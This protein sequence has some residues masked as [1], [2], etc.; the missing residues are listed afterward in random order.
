MKIKKEYFV[1]DEW[2]FIGMFDESSSYY[3]HFLSDND[4]YSTEIGINMIDDM[5][6]DDEDNEIDDNAILKLRTC[7]EFIRTLAKEN[8]LKEKDVRLVLL[9]G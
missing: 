5:I 3:E 6:E 9:R 2:D 7:Q 1:I 8:N 4:G